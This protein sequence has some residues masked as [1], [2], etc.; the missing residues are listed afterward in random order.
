MKK[1]YFSVVFLLLIISGC[2]GTDSVTVGIKIGMQINEGDKNGGGDIID[3]DAINSLDRYY[4]IALINVDGSS[5]G[6]NKQFAFAEYSAYK[7][8][9]YY[10]ESEI[11][12][13]IGETLSISFTGFYYVND[14]TVGGFRSD[15]TYDIKIVDGM[16]I[17][18]AIESVDLP[19]STLKITL[20]DKSIKSIVLQDVYT[21]TLLRSVDV[22]V[23]NGVF[24]QTI[25]EGEYNILGK[26]SSNN[27]K[28]LIGNVIIKGSDV[29]LSL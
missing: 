27:D 12:G 3:S 19:R 8:G 23:M 9:N 4:A 25:P 2:Y 17:D 1:E 11:Y 15:G 13:N 10:L 16:D 29:N 21:G 5:T 26:D 7:A 20:T 22:S 6:N 28:Q 18:F 24:I 14:T